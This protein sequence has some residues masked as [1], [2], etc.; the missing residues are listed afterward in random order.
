MITQQF[1]QSYQEV[2]LF[3]Y[4]NVQYY[5]S[6]NTHAHPRTAPWVGGSTAPP[7][8]PTA[9]PCS[10]KGVG[11]LSHKRGVLQSCEVGGRQ[12]CQFTEVTRSWI[13][14]AH[15]VKT[16]VSCTAALCTYVAY[17]P[18]H[19]YHHIQHIKSHS[20][21]CEQSAVWRAPAVRAGLAV[22]N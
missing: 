10:G 8:P 1:A 13:T 15:N 2:H 21:S 9:G 14:S 6:I 18:W 5:P 17:C 3:H 4:V 12:H 11:S 20:I 22:A 7:P 19:T 16:Q